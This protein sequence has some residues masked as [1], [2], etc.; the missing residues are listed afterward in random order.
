[1][2]RS[3]YPEA[4]VC[5]LILEK[6]IRF[7]VTAEDALSVSTPLASALGRRVI[8]VGAS[9]SGKSTLG[10]RLA[11]LMAVPFVELDALFWKPGWVES[12]DEEFCAKASEATTG[13]GW[14]VAGGYHR[15]TTA[16]IWPRAE[17]VIW[18]DLPLR[19]TV[20]RILRRSWMRWRRHELLWGTNEEKF[21]EQLKLWSRNDSLIAFTVGTRH[22]RHRRYLGAMSDPQW[23]HIRFI[24][25]RTA[26][27][28]DLFAANVEAAFVA[29]DRG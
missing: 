24:R 20:W 22:E 13:E 10:E 28:V 3:E 19:V 12:E 29:A 21:W 23:A 5:I 27:E 18:L 1:M 4:P 26:A 8:I 6:E 25:L 9:S 14:V 11:E 15:Q 16:T 17:T 2:V 7:P